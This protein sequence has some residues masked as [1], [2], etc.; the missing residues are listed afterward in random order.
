MQF[1]EDEIAVQKL[2]ADFIR[3]EKLEIAAHAREDIATANRHAGKAFAT[4][5]T[6]AESTLGRRALEELMTHDLPEIRLGAA[7]SV[8]AWDSEAAIPVLGQLVA[9]W[10]PGDA[11]K[12]YVAVSTDAKLAL[13][14]HFGVRDFNPNKLIAPLRKYGIHLERVPE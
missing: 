11:Q 9:T 13:Y 14:D 3:S 2:A 1:P 12:G 8:M 6:L 4:R 7:I 5:R 10:K